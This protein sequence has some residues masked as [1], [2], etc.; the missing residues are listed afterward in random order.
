MRCERRCVRRCR[1]ARRSPRADAS[2]ARSAFALRA[3]ATTTSV[4]PSSAASATAPSSTRC[5]RCRSRTLSLPLS[6]SPSAPLTTTTGLPRPAGDRLELARSRKPCSAAAVKAARLEQRVQRR[7]AAQIER[8]VPGEV[9]AERHGAVG[10][11]PGEQTW[12]AWHGPL[13]EGAHA[14]VPCTVP[15]TRVWL[16]CSCSP[17]W[18][19]IVRS[20]PSPA[21]RCWCPGGRRC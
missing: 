15:V 12:Y 7:L 20:P 9:L 3:T 17:I 1:R 13:F 18:R 5:G 10:V 19:S 8:A 2:A 21:P 6:G 4:V 14:A 11:Q 16:G